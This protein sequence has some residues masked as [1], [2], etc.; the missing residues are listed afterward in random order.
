MCA[1]RS[2]SWRNIGV[3]KEILQIRGIMVGKDSQQIGLLVIV[4]K[5]R[6]CMM[7]GWPCLA[8]RSL[9]K[10]RHGDVHLGITFADF[11]GF[12]RQRSLSAERVCHGVLVALCQYLFSFYH[13]CGGD[14]PSRA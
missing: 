7:H 3:V 8:I 14:V 12:R 4:Y 9:E 13:V 10:F 11:L 6:Y 2:F 1:L 5:L